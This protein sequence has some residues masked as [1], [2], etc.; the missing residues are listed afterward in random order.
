[1][2]IHEW[3]LIAAF[4]LAI[5]IGLSSVNSTLAVAV[6]FCSAFT[7][8]NVVGQSQNWNVVTIPILGISTGLILTGLYYLA[9]RFSPWRKAAASP[10]A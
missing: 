9:K 6:L 2:T 7:V 4:L 5:G 8:W 10:P 1:M 3:M